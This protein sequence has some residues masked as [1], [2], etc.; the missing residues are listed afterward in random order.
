[1]P[2]I[3]TT[4]YLDDEHY[5]KFKTYCATYT[6]G[7]YAGARTLLEWAIDEWERR[8]QAKQLAE[9]KSRQQSEKRGEK[10]VA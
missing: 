1:M 10:Q 3:G 7:D 4:V 6:C 2:A 5:K 8:E 9:A